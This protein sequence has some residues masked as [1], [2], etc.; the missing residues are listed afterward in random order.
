MSVLLRLKMLELSVMGLVFYRFEPLESC[1]KRRGNVEGQ[2]KSADR[3]SFCFRNN[4]SKH[5][6]IDKWRI[7]LHVIC[8]NH[9][10][11]TA[12][13]RSRILSDGNLH[14]FKLTIIVTT[15]SND[16]QR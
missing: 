8:K 11:W 4:T 5:G 9:E 15:G 10:K 14:K 12:S 13:E 7:G 16:F 2:T 1:L 6:E 3:P